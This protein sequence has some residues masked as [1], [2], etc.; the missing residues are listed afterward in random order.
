MD[1][2][3]SIHG[4]KVDSNEPMESL[5]AALKEALAEAESGELRELVLVSGYKNDSVSAFYGGEGRYVMNV[6]AQLT[7]VWLTYREDYINIDS[8][9][10][11]G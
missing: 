10:E 3:T 4:G 5:V 11:L 7:H 2:V 9:D 1:K 8:T 6:Y